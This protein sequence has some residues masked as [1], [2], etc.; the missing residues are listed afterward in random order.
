MA[1]NISVAPEG[2]VLV[3]HNG[4]LNQ[5]TVLAATVDSFELLGAEG[6]GRVM[7]DLTGVTSDLGS[8]QMFD[9]H[10]KLERFNSVARPRAA[11][12]VTSEQRPAAQFIE[13]VMVNRGMLAKVF[14]DRAPA[15]EWLCGTATASPPT[16]RAG[17]SNSQPS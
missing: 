11:F 13:N 9:A 8:F 12:L 15:V 4:E 3:E 2:F 7:I 6:L 16:H 1:Y 5:H 10:A 14:T 17:N